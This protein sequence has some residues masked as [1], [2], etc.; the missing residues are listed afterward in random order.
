MK[1]CFNQWLCSVQSM[2]N[3]FRP[4]VRQ[5]IRAE[6]RECDGAML[7]MPRQLGRKRKTRRDQNPSVSIKHTPQWPNFLSWFSTR[8]PPTCDFA[9]NTCTFDRHIQTMWSKPEQTQVLNWWERASQHL[10]FREE[11]QFECQWEHS[12]HH[13]GVRCIWLPE[14]I[15][16]VANF[17]FYSLEDIR[18]MTYFKL[19][20]IK[21]SN[22][23]LFY[24]F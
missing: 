7:P 16:I 4:V 6:Q 24:H 9:L 12:T 14:N 17:H 18:L 3:D 11:E 15:M 1:V 23:I 21:R 2:A 8:E 13:N 22:R 19:L 5:N 20:R 10:P